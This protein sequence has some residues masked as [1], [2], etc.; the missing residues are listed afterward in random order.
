MNGMKPR[1]SLRRFQS[2]FALAL[3]VGAL[4]VLSDKFL[5]VDN[6]WNILRRRV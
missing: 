6:G 5:T 1:F 2:L 3:M 4:A